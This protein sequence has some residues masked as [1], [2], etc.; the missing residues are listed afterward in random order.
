MYEMDLKR[1]LYGVGHIL[2]TNGRNI[3]SFGNGSILRNFIN[4]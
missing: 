4:F 2:V 3:T 1:Y